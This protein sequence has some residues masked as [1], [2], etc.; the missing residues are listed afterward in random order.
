MLEV[1]GHVAPASTAGANGRK[2]SR[3]LILRFMTRLHRRDRGRRRGCCGRRGARPNSMRPWNQPTTLSSP[4][5][6][7]RAR[8]ASRRRRSRWYGAP[9]RVEESRISSSE[10]RARGSEPFWH[11][12]RGYV[13]RASPSILVPDEQR[14]PERPAGVARGGLNPDFSKGPSRR[15]RPLPTQFSATPPARHRFSLAGLAH[16][17]GAPC[18]A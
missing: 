3:N 18:A 4:A 11:R 2:L 6:R 16:A 17:R 13:V 5:A 8:T 1:V 9:A 7:P 15:I 12:R 10:K 14:G